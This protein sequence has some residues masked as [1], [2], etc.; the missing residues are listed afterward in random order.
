M[1]LFHGYF[2]FQRKQ[3][4]LPGS[5]R[6]P[7]SLGSTSSITRVQSKQQRTLWDGREVV[8]LS[9]SWLPP[10]NVWLKCFSSQVRY[11]VALPRIFRYNPSWRSYILSF[12]INMDPHL[13]QALEVQGEGVCVAVVSRQHPQRRREGGN[14]EEKRA[15][16][17]WVTSGVSNGLWGA[18]RA[19]ES[20]YPWP[21]FR[22]SPYTYRA[23]AGFDPI[24]LFNGI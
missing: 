22:P 8:T 1:P 23:A 17:T 7:G 24:S 21:H 18:E 4:K 14:S 10:H 16:C 3:V 13:I 6:C 9:V 15:G 11:V 20:S 2:P 19:Q 5:C 12:A